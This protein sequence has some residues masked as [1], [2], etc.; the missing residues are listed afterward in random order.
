MRMCFAF[1]ASRPKDRR[2]LTEG[3]QMQAAAV[4]AK[5]VL[6]TRREAAEY[7]GVSASTLSTWAC[8]DRYQLPYI[9]IGGRLVRYRKEDLDAFIASGRVEGGI[10]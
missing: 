3:K 7:L 2:K 8:N 10:Q 4:E 5:P 9:K 1:E 6:L